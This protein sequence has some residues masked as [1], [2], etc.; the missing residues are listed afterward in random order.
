MLFYRAHGRN[1]NPWW[2][3]SDMSG[4]FDLPPESGG[5]CYLARDRC[6]ALREALGAR[7]SRAVVVPEIECDRRRISRLSLPWSV[8]AADTATEEAA[9][10]GVTREMSASAEYG[11]TQRWA[12]RLREDGFG[13]ISYEGR[14]N[15]ARDAECLALFS[16][17]PGQATC[18]ED[19]DPQ[20]A[21][22]V[23]VDCGIRIAAPPSRAA[24]TVT[25]PPSD[26]F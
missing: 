21:T 7:L 22:E 17:T 10:Y 16:D 4:R 11:L 18:A 13:A 2:F 12:L 6:T 14:F 23:A 26:T 19:P 3:S 24:L 15:P 5:T 9:G 8:H 1:R 20:A 25:R